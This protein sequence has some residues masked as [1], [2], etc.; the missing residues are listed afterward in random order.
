MRFEKNF[1]EYLQETVTNKVADFRMFFI[2][3]KNSIKDTIDMLNKSLKEICFNPNPT[4]YI[5][6]S[7]TQRIS[8]DV[9]EFGQKL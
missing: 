2:K 5:K 3:W 4:T 6:I 1:D 8:K 9:Y 7:N